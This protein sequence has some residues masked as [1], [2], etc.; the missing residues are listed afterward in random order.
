MSHPVTSMSFSRDSR[1]LAE[2]ARVA[3][4]DGVEFA[5]EMPHGESR[6]T[7][8]VAAGAE[9]L[10]VKVAPGGP[11][12]LEN[13]ERLVRLVVALRSKGYPAPEY[14]GAGQADGVAF[15]VQRLLP[16]KTLDPVPGQEL[17]SA[18]LPDLLAAIELQAGAGDLAE[19]PW[20]G[21]LL[22]TIDAG[23]DGYC[24]HETMRRAR[25]TTLL[26]D[27][28]QDLARR[29]RDLPVRR[30][31][32]VHFDMNPAN[33]LHEGARLS[34]VVDWNMPFTGACQGD[35][36]F[37]VATLLFYSYDLPATRETLWEH[38]TR[39]SGI[40]WTTVYLCHLSLRQVEWVRRHYPGTPAE[41]RF[42]GIAWTILDDCEA[43]GGASA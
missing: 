40:G 37:D 21:W 5:G 38:A 16:G 23:G 32:V 9:Q 36:G 3:G 7:F 42:T 31:D 35:R 22:D 25:G 24:L 27:R 10:V 26:L 33:I 28:L 13:Q 17:F 18:L 12:A 43:R 6:S 19:P 34:G 2:V 39:I 1:V 14:L 15:T 4:T 20:P 30:G 29:N 41:T 8:I 11:S